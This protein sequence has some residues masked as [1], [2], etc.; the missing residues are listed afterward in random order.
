M[1]LKTGQPNDDN[2]MLIKV[3]KNADVGWIIFSAMPGT[4]AKLP[5]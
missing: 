3:G 2:I 4:I 1:V 5:C